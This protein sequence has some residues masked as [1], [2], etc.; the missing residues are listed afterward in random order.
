YDADLNRKERPKL[1]ETMSRNLRG[2]SLGEF[3][4]K[5]E[6]GAQVVDT[7]EATE[8]AMAYLPGS[9][10]IG[11]SGQ[12]ATWAGTLL[13]PSRPILVIAEPGREQEAERR[14]GRIGCDRV[15]G[16]LEGGIEAADSPPGLLERTERT[17]AVTVAEELESKNPP[18]VLDVRAPG[19]RSQKR[20]EGSLHIPLN[21]LRDRLSEIP[22]DRAIVTQ[23]A[24][25]YPSSIAASL[26]RQNGFRDVRDLVGGIAAWEASRL[27]V[28]S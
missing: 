17:T 4:A 23:C 25:G 2:L 11:L 20:I 3:L 8:F 22:R 6:Q 27:A 18:L 5:R 7:R 9:L 13:D 16:Y 14:L 15:E 1:E 21:H 28:V 12:Y 24:S 26:L 19:E 10:N